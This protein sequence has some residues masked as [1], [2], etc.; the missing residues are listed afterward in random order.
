MP[1]PLINRIKGHHFPQEYLCLENP[2]QYP[3]RAVWRDQ[4]LTGIHFFLGYQP[5][6]IGIPYKPGMPE[7]LYLDFV[8]AGTG[9]KKVASLKLKGT[10]ILKTGHHDLQLYTC[11]NGTHQLIPPFYR[12]INHSIMFIRSLRKGNIRLKGNRYNQV[13]IAYSIPRPIY[14]ISVGEG[15]LYNIFPTDLFGRINETTFIISLRMAGKAC[16][17]VQ[18]YRKIVLSEMQA[19]SFKEVYRLG[20]NHNRDLSVPDPSICSGWSE[21]WHLPLPKDILQYHELE[22]SHHQDFGI[23]RLLVFNLH[24]SKKIQ[25]GPSLAHIH[26]YA[27]SWL[28]RGQFEM[29]YH[30]R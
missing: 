20:K 28:Q 1:A 9:S 15:D 27:A 5:V 23:H 12:F 18:M 4:D 6:I 16:G 30:F 25:D 21:E 11:L 8:S 24:K 26:N 10:A 22:Y 14:L 19:G 7:V 3:L 2:E 13:R 29:K 17:Q